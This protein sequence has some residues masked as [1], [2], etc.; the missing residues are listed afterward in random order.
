MVFKIAIIFFAVIGFTFS[1]LVTFFTLDEYGGN[2]WIWTKNLFL[3]PYYC[4]RVILSRRFAEMI[5]R[6]FKRRN[7]YRS[8][9]SLR[10]IFW[11]VDKKL[12]R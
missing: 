2:L 9:W 8:R 1:L 7:N 5:D 6:G 12:G 4:I 11:F 3:T 10:I